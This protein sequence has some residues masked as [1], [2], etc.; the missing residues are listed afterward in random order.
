MSNE[1]ED[2]NESVSCKILGSHVMTMNNA[3]FWDVKPCGSC[4]NL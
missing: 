4:K 3:V 1:T 2:V